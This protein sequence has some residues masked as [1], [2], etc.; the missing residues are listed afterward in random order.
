MRSKGNCDHNER[1][2]AYGRFDISGITLGHVSHAVKCI[3]IKCQRARTRARA[4]MLIFE[5][6]ARISL[7]VYGPQHTRCTSRLI[8]NGGN[9]PANLG[10]I[11]AHHRDHLGVDQPDWMREPSISISNGN[12]NDGTTRTYRMRRQAMRSRWD[13]QL[14]V[15]PNIKYRSKRALRPKN[16]NRMSANARA[17]ICVRRVPTPNRAREPR[18]M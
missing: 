15:N 12:A 7:S 2:I 3:S 1:N 9:H 17:L 10:T 6:T 8:V 18:T 16:G 13:F 14:I 5:R 4:E 11:V